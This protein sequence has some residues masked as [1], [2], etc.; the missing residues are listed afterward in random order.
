MVAG[1]LSYN[2]LRATHA[3]DV[4]VPIVEWEPSGGQPRGYSAEA[5][6]QRKEALATLL[7]WWPAFDEARL[8]AELRRLRPHGTAV[9]MSSL[10]ETEAGE[11]EL[12]LIS[13]LADVRLRDDDDDDDANDGAADPKKK[14][15]SPSAESQAIRT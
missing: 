7:R 2:F 15:A 1:L 6:A 3:A 11:T 12:D 4:V 9:F 13:D 14:P 10:W 8:L 5:A